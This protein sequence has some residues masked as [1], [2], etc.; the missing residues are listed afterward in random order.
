MV[1]NVE[2]LRLGCIGSPEAQVIAVWGVQS[3][4]KTLQ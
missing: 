2:V 1:G 3:T 4:C